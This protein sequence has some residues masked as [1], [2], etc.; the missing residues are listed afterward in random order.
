MVTES[1]ALALRS[2][3]EASSL[4]AKIAE[5][6]LIP[7]AMQKRLPDVLVAI[8]AGQEMGLAPMA[9]LRSIHVVEGKPIMSADGMV[10]IILGSGKAQYFDRI[11]ATDKSVTYETLRI[12]SKTPQRCTWTMEMAKIAAVNNKDNWR[13]YPRQMLAARAK[14]ELARD[15]YPDVLAG[16]YTED[17]AEEFDR[18]ARQPVATEDAIDAEIVDAPPE[19]EAMR[20]AS[21]IDELKA[22]SAALAARKL[23]PGQARDAA[24]AV[25]KERIDWLRKQPA[26]TANAAAP[27]ET[28]P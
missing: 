18:I 17:E 28:A 11:E 1:K 4:A 13:C 27:Q 23:P 14:A 24:A 12:G 2:I 8:L 9:S 15:V 26:D 7:K 25:Y 16:C 5:S 20:S 19:I 10:A 21:T 6:T 3:D 22:L